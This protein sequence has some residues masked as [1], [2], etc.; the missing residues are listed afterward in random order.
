MDLSDLW[1]EHKRFLV[2]VGLGAFAFLIGMWTIEAVYGDD[3]AAVRGSRLSLDRNLRQALYSRSDLDE[4]ERQNEALRAAV[5]EL[6]AAVESRPRERFLLGSEA[7][8]GGSP[9]IQFQR[10][11]AAL[12]DE[13]LPLA[14]RNN[15]DLEPTLGLPSLSP[16]EDY[17]I[18]RYL[19]ALDVLDRAVRLAMDAGVEAIENVRIKLDPGLLSRAGVGRIERTRIELQLAGPSRALTAFLAATQRP[20]E[21]EDDGGG[22]ALQ[23]HEF[24]LS[25]GRA[26]QTRL[27]LVLV[28]ARLHR[29]AD[30]GEV[31]G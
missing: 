7:M 30:E 2:T 12:R 9:S 6:A 19:E 21:G 27:E 17:K 4:A 10:T 14:G 25:T 23:V 31:E 13:L 3:L 1:Q 22:R 26:D 28:V 18:E 29:A 24:E 8:G 11:V 15:L 5:D 16:T 20:G